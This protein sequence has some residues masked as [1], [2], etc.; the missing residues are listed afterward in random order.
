MPFKPNYSFQ[1]AERERA[2]AAK[3][4]AKKQERAERRKA[5]EAAAGGEGNA[6]T[7]APAAQNGEQRPT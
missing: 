5:E 7:D 2:K 1:R 3:Q 4:D 6:P